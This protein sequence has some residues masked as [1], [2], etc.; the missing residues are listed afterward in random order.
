LKID[1]ED[2]D[3]I[4]LYNYL[5]GLEERDTFLRNSKD[6]NHISRFPI[7]VFLATAIFCMASSAIFHLF[8]SMN[9][10]VN[11]VLL[12]LDYAGISIL[13]FGSTV[14]PLYYGFYCQ[15]QFYL[16]YLVANFIACGTVFIIS[17]CDFIH[18]DKYRRLK[19]IMYGSLGVASGL[20]AF[21]LLF[22]E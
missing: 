19:G 16:I 17:L 7:F 12:R 2:Y 3:W 10:K 4:E 9:E 1:S 8:Y 15:P 20:P 5:P 13:I 6:P 21:H 14:G 18:R 11:K 22:L